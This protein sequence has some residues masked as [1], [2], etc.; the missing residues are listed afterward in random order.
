MQPCREPA[1]LLKYSL[2]GFFAIQQQAN[3]VITAIEA[4]KREILVEQ[5]NARK[6]MKNSW[7]L[8]SIIKKKQEKS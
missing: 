6:D 2:F 8:R 1:V 3:I 5:R 4:D 7:Q